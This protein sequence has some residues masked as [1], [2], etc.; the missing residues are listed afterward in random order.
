[1]SPWQRETFEFI[2]LLTSNSKFYNDFK[3]LRQVTDHGLIMSKVTGWIVLKK[4]FCTFGSIP[5]LTPFSLRSRFF[6][7]PL[8]T[9]I[10]FGCLTRDLQSLCVGPEFDS[11]SPSI[12]SCFN[13]R[14]LRL[15]PL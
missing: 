5:T 8:N 12:G 13:L 1:M 6:A 9:L 14:K 11:M 10:Y 15:Y 7:V 3:V 2:S 4:Q